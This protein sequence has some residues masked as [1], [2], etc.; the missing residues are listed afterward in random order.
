MICRP[1]ASGSECVLSLLLTTYVMRTS[2]V[3]PRPCPH[4]HRTRDVYFDKDVEPALPLK[5]MYDLENR[6]LARQAGDLGD[7]LMPIF[8]QLLSQSSHPP[9]PSEGGVRP[10]VSR[11]RPLHFRGGWG[12]SSPNP[13]CPLEH[14]KTG[15][16]GT[17]VQGKFVRNYTGS[18][19]PADMQSEV[20]NSLDKKRK[21]PSGRASSSMELLSRLR[22]RLRVL[23]LA[24]QRVKIA[25]LTLRESLTTLTLLRAASLCR[26]MSSVMGALAVLH[27]KDCPAFRSR[28]CAALSYK[29]A[30]LGLTPCK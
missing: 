20:W 21:K 15:K 27:P 25:T 14:E 30:S 19:R 2:R 26:S 17:W 28:P 1:A 29:E 13:R 9:V 11:G 23:P 3:G 24:P 12:V 18:T 22:I 16:N 5:L 8:F 6:S 4:I 10:P 7:L